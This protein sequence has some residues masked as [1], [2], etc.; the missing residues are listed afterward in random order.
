LIVVFYLDDIGSEGIKVTPSFCFVA[1][2]LSEALPAICD[3][4][5]IADWYRVHT[6]FDGAG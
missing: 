2:F 5:L 1:V 4:Y 3:R 6:I